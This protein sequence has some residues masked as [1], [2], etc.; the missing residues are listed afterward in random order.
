MGR[1][2]AER[3]QHGADVR[4][5]VVVEHLFLGCGQ[6]TH[7]DDLDVVR[8]ERRQHHLVEALVLVLDQL[9]GSLPD[10]FLDDRGLHPIGRVR[11]PERLLL[12]LFQAGDHVLHAVVGAQVAAE[13]DELEL[14]LRRKLQNAQTSARSVNP[15]NTPPGYADAVAEYYKRLSKQ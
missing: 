13:V 2:E 8:G 10:L 9:E 5:E 4:F 7:L 1:V 15:R 3:G 12:D 6:L 14:M 11:D